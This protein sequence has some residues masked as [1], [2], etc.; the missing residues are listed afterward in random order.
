MFLGLFEGSSG[1]E[2]EGPCTLMV[3]EICIRVALVIYKPAA[4]RPIIPKGCL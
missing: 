4:K 2:P 3:L 1:S